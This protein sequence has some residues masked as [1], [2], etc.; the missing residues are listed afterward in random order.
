MDAS[1]LPGGSNF[2]DVTQLF[3]DAAADMEPSEVV[4]MPGFTLQDAMCAF[5]IG[6]PRLDSGMTPEGEQRPLFDPWAPMLPEEICWIIDRMFT[7]EML[8]HAGNTLVHTVF[9]CLYGLAISEIWPDII[10]YDSFPD[11]QRLPELVPLVLRAAVAGML[12]CCDLSWR[13]LSKGYVQDTEDWHSEKGDISLLEGTSTA[14]VVADIDTAVAWLIRS[15]KVADPWC[16]GLIARLNLR[17]SLIQLMSINLFNTPSDFLDLLNIARNHL[18][19]VRMYP[20]HEPTPDSPAHLSFDPYI[21]RKLNSSVPI[22]IIPVPP[23]AETWDA[24][25]TLLD[26]WDEQRLLSMTPTVTT[27]EASTPSGSTPPRT[28]C[29]SS[30]QSIFYDG[31][32]VLNKFS[33]QWV[34]DR[35]FFETLGVGYQSVVAYVGQNSTDQFWG[36][37]QRGHFKLMTEYVRAL[38]YNPPRRRR[39]LAKM[40]T[41]LHLY[42]SRMMGIAAKF[43]P[44]PS[45]AVYHFP[46]CVLLWRLSV[47]REVVLSGFQLELYTS[48]EK[49]FA[50]W[51]AS[52]V[53]HAH[54]ECLDELLS[55]VDPNC[56]AGRELRFQHSWLSALQVMTLSSF[57]LSMSLMSFNWRQMQANFFRRYKWAFGS[58]YEIASVP[59]V[60]LPSFDGFMGLCGRLLED[61]QFSPSA[62]FQ[63]AE[64]I[65]EGLITSRNVGGYSGLW[66]D[67]RI[68]FLRGLS[69]ACRRLQDVPSSMSA[70]PS[71]DVGLL[72]WDPTIHPWFPVLTADGAEW[73]RNKHRKRRTSI[74]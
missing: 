43:P 32:L 26:G 33:P 44:D 31:L 53:L 42:Y 62:S 17:K 60:A 24:L 13:E 73:R 45:Q 7:Y 67:E 35:F 20:S 38:W 55:A 72:K 68:A 58:G 28:D 14:N 47:V 48:E 12:K 49:S 6:E 16:T 70:V 4:L 56:P 61:P 9:T 5:E 66:T 50:Y 65:L 37:L 19:T 41:D 51:Y 71:F 2:R 8:W 15:R 10:P 69:A 74:H 27:W 18:K 46:K 30:T 36:D 63:L 64:T 3:V 40:L 34:M 57:A 22:R 11:T 52:Q 25:D 59:V 29:E 1:D 23:I 21:A 54:L 39:F